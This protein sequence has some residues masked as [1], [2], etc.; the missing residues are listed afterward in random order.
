[1]VEASNAFQMVVSQIDAVCDKLKVKD[2]WR[3][4]LEN[5]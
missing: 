5:C 4:R 1:M 2:A 3:L